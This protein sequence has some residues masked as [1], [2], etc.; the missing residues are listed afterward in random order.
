MGIPNAVCF[1]MIANLQV[2]VNQ[3]YA[4]GCVCQLDL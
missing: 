3:N 2:T 4:L 1:G